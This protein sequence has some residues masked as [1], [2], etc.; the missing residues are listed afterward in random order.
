[1]R[2]RTGSAA[3]R[4]AICRTCLGRGQLAGQAARSCPGCGGRGVCPPE[5][6]PDPMEAVLAPLMAR[7]GERRGGLAQVM[8]T[9]RQ[10]VPDPPTPP[11]LRSRYGSGQADGSVVFGA[12]DQDGLA[13]QIALRPDGRIAYPDGH[14]HDPEQ[15]RAEY[16]RD[17]REITARAFLMDAFASGRPLAHQE[18]EALADYLCLGRRI[19]HELVGDR[20][21]YSPEDRRELK[22]LRAEVA[23]AIHTRRLA[24]PIQL[25][26]APRPDL[27]GVSEVPRPDQVA[28][29]RWP[30]LM[31]CSLQRPR[32]A[33]GPVYHL[34]VPSGIPALWSVP[35]LGAR[36]GDHVLLEAG[37]KVRPIGPGPKMMLDDLGRM[38]EVVTATLV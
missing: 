34:S 16:R 22:E 4:P 29:I 21:A 11:P 6:A 13:E 17:R 33:T 31:V 27:T 10:L 15:V 1:M 35:E 14:L 18:R 25:W 37:L 20:E 5:P 3:P 19:D 32:Q 24:E 23:G 12:Y 26:W 28:D 8:R 30:A 7:A 9:P 2:R 36:A 38:R